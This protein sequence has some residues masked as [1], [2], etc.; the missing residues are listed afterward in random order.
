MVL[1]VT[2]IAA[3]LAACASDTNTPLATPSIYPTAVPTP[4][5]TPSSKPNPLGRLYLRAARPYNRE[6]CSFNARFTGTSPSMSEIQPAVLVLAASLQRFVDRLRAIEWNLDLQ[7]EVNALI[8]AGSDQE[9]ILRGMA[10][11]DSEAD[12]Y[13]LDAQRGDANVEATAAANLVRGALGIESM[14][15]DPCHP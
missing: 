9:T 10:A 8:A 13:R 2:L 7:D 6:L 4:S 11:A 15:G 3:L 1:K 14:G 12:F 5:L